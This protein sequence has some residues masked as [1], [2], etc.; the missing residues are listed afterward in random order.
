MEHRQ[1][2]EAQ[3]THEP[4][5]AHEPHEAQVTNAVHKAQ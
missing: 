4:H 1:S 5:I 3:M 2:H